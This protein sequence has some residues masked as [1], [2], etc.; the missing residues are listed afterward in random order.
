MKH[1][2]NNVYLDSAWVK[3]ETVIKTHVCLI[4]GLCYYSCQDL[5]LS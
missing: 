4:I 1:A 5:V 3:I 2:L